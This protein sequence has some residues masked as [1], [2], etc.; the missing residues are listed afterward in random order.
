MMVL[1]RS[2]YD[3]YYIEAAEK[4]AYGLDIPTGCVVRGE[5]V[6]DKCIVVVE[7]HAVSQVITAVMVMAVADA[8]DHHGIGGVH[9]AV[10]VFAFQKQHFVDDAYAFPFG[11]SLQEGAAVLI[12]RIAAVET[13][14]RDEGCAMYE[15]GG[16]ADAEKTVVQE[17]NHLFAGRGCGEG[18]SVR[19]ITAGGQNGH[20]QFCPRRPGLLVGVPDGDFRLPGT[21]LHIGCYCVV[22]KYVVTVEAF[23]PLASGLTKSGVVVG[24]HA[25]VV[26]CLCLDDTDKTALVRFNPSGSNTRRIVT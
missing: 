12:H 17:I 26:C 15:V 9:Q 13:A 10:G 3:V 14:L 18:G 25:A 20:R 16:S 2:I 7:W 24:C 21:M 22:G 23:D 1:L 5:P 8:L 4:V 6:G 11:E 19:I